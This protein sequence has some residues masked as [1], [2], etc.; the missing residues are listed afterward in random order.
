[1]NNFGK[2]SFIISFLLFLS[3]CEFTKSLTGYTYDAADARRAQ[4]VAVGQIIKMETVKINGTGGDIGALG[5]AAA[6]GIA[7]SNIGGGRGQMLGTLGGALAGGIAGKIFAEK[8]T[9]KT[10]VNFF[11]KLCSGKMISV[12]QEN[13]PKRP[14]RVGDFVYMLSSR[15]S[16]RITFNSDGTCAAGKDNAHILM[17]KHSKVKR[18]V[19]QTD[20][21]GVH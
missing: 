7:G 4:S 21:M 12:I 2:I 13:D 10:A 5:G 11:V 3:G 16:T 6:G 14:L 17:H 9:S 15:G 20:T 19:Q 8:I 18:H 1:M